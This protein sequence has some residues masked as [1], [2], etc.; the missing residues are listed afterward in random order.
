[1]YTNM[2]TNMYVYKY[3]YNLCLHKCNLVE[4]HLLLNM[5]YLSIIYCRKN[6]NI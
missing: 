2:Y 5:L 4:F 3:V 6:V 1:M